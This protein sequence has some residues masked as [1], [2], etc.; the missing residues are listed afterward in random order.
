M[1]ACVCVCVCVCARVREWV[2]E[3]ML[4]GVRRIGIA[5]DEGQEGRDKEERIRMHT[6]T[7]SP[8]TYIH[9]HATHLG[10]EPLHVGKAAG[11]RQLEAS[12]T[13][14]ETAETSY[15]CVL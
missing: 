14:R 1:Y 7:P 3:G 10:P 2:C 5:S 11:A 12:E 13:A 4:E 15:G 8:P 9:P 6:P